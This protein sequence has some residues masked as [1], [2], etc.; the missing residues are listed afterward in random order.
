MSSK[1]ISARKRD[2]RA[3]TAERLEAIVEAAERAAE[4]VIDDAEAQARAYLAE[5][6]ERADREARRRIAPL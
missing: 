4:G 3:S 6:R 2:L 1:D 5:A